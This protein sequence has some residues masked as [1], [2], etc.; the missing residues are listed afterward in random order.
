M[1][2]EIL[3]IL[4]KEDLLKQ[5]MEE[6]EEMLS[7]VESMFRSAMEMVINCKSPEIDIYK[8]DKKIDEMELDIRQKVLEH[9]II[10][11]R[12]ED[13]SA[14]LVLTSISREIERIGDY[15]KN[16]FEL[17]DIC[18][19]EFVVG[20]EGAESLKEIE[21]QVLKLFSL[22]QQAH[23]EGNEQKARAVMEMQLQTAKQC[24]EIFE[25]LALRPGLSTEYAIMY[26]LLSRYLLRISSHLKNI[27]S[28]IINPFSKTDIEQAG[29]KQKS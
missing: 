22:T 26:A 25:Y 17:V 13:F 6:V 20:G 4:R 24:N 19:T 21:N 7:M 3:A 18:P 23:K 12:K 29:E 10:G 2:K 14:A 9:L 1:F 5:S 27:A 11:D 28:N 16:I 8:I 15:S